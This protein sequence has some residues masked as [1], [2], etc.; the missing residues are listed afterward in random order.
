MEHRFATGFQNGTVHV[1]MFGFIIVMLAA[2]G[3]SLDLS[4]VYN[5][6]V[7]MENVADMAALAAA[8]NLD[9]TPRGISNAVAAA[10]G[11][12][13]SLKYGYGAA[14]DWSDSAIKFSKSSDGAQGWVDAGTAAAAP[15]GLLYAMVDTSG[16]AAISG[17]VKLTFMPIF[18][19]AVR[20][21][22]VRQVAVAGRAS[23]DVTP[24]GVCAVDPD[25]P[26]SQHAYTS[27]VELVEFGFRRGLTYDLM[28]LNPTLVDPVG[29]PGQAASASNFSLSIVGPHVCA[30]TVAAPTLSGGRIAIQ[31]P[32]PLSS[33]AAHLNSRFDQYN[34]SCNPNAAPPDSNVR[35]YTSANATW[36]TSDNPNYVPL[37]AYARAV[38]WSSYVPGQP[39]PLNGYT[40]FGATST[41]AHDLYSLLTNFKS[42]YPSGTATPYLSGAFSTQPSAGHRP[43]LKYR[44]VLNVPLLRCPIS[45]SSADVVGIGRF[46]MTVPATS[47]A[48]LAE[49]AGAITDDLAG[50][51]VEIF[52]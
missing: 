32:F 11:V 2:L 24:L 50:G 21:V 46:F 47:T 1:M 36:V 12:V 23:L 5:R 52:K 44:R 33:L 30:G 6:K 4:Q 3:M 25:S 16:L 17:A 39:E 27:N 14:M 13:R 10:S 35:S 9:G 15:Q 34:G 51:N 45:G 49:F 42:S 29:A 8:R 28:S 19:P 26:A 22:S 37:W 31:Q 40:T 38:P 20:S 48:V 41:V 7:E 43:G 18:N